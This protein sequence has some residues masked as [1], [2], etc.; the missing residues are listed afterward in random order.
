MHRVVRNLARASL[1]QQLP[2]AYATRESC[3]YTVACD[4][5]HKRYTAD[6]WANT[7][8]EGLIQVDAT[9][10]WILFA[11]VDGSPGNMSIFDPASPSAT[12]IVNLAILTFVVTGLI[13]IIVKGVLL[14]SLWRFRQ[15]TGEQTGEPPQVYGS[16]PIEIAW[17]AA[18]IL[19]VFFLVLVT[20]R[21]LWEVEHTA[22]QTRPGDNALFVTVIGHQWWWEYVYESYN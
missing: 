21:T 2:H 18:P 17:T 12:S 20:T 9:G 4:S 10:R 1:V 13:F 8:S 11:A 5:R 14:D 3:S 15:P 19:I 7:R 22:P 6:Q 16:I